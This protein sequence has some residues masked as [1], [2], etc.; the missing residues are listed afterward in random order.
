MVQDLEHLF[1]NSED[2]PTQ[3]LD[4]D[5]QGRLNDL[6]QSMGFRDLG[7]LKHHLRRLTSEQKQALLQQLQQIPADSSDLKAQVQDKFNTALEASIDQIFTSRNLPPP[8]FEPEI[9]SDVTLWNAASLASVHDALKT[10]EAQNPERLATLSREAGVSKEGEYK[11]LTFVREHN[12]QTTGSENFLK[13]ISE[14]TMIAHSSTSSGEVHIYDAAISGDNTRVTQ[15]VVDKMELLSRLASDK[16]GRKELVPNYTHDEIDS[17]GLQQR[18]GESEHDYGQRLRETLTD[19]YV[20]RFGGWENLQKSVNFITRYRDLV[21]RGEHLRDHPIPETGEEARDAT[22]AALTKLQN[23]GSDK[24]LQVACRMEQRDGIGH[25]QSFLKENAPP[26]TN[27]SNLE[28]DGI[29]G[30]RTGGVVKSFQ[31]G[32]AVNTFKERIEDDPHLPENKKEELIRFCNEQFRTL[33]EQPGKTNEI[34]GQ[35]RTRMQELIDGQEITDNTRT[36]L[37]EDVDNLT[38]LSHS[39]EGVFNRDTAEKMVNNWFNLVDSGRGYDLGEQLTMHELGHIWET[40]LDREKGNLGIRENWNKLF[41]SA[42]HSEGDGTSQMNTQTANDELHSDTVATTAYGSAEPDE[43]FAE[44][45]RVFAYDPKRLMRRS[46][47]KFLFMNHINHDQYDTSKILSMAHECGYSNDQILSRLDNLLGRGDHNIQFSG[48]FASEM[49]Q[50]YANLRAQLGSAPEPVDSRLNFNLSLGMNPPG[51]L[52]TLSSTLTPPTFTSEMMNPEPMNSGSFQLTEPTLSS[53]FAPGNGLF[54]PTTG[55]WSSFDLNQFRLPTSTDNSYR[56]QPNE[57][58]WVLD[59]V[60]N[61]YQDLQRQLSVPGLP[62]DQRDV[63]QSQIRQLDQQILQNGPGALTGASAEAMTAVDKAI[64]DQLCQGKSPNP[65]DL[66]RGYAVMAA[67]SIYQAT[68]AFDAR[69]HPELAEKLP[70]TFAI[71]LQDPN[72][73]HLLSPE[74]ARQYNQSYLFSSTLHQMDIIAQRMDDVQ[75]DK[76]MV[77]DTFADLHSNLAAVVDTSG[78]PLSPQDARRRADELLQDP[79]VQQV[80]QDASYDIGYGLKSLQTFAT[81]I[82]GLSSQAIHAMKPKDFER[83]MLM[84]MLTGQDRSQEQFSS[85]VSSYVYNEKAITG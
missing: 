55:L 26:G 9:G 82:G 4:S 81:S 17:R 43:D 62:D 40:Q 19:D 78:G 53:G 18:P 23:L 41:D 42:A 79:R 10:I 72:M 21:Y 37:S 36:H 16:N 30:S 39:R 66:K 74:N 73:Q 59:A 76:A 29:L 48:S 14:S 6:A 60:S 70:P 49:S 38:Q 32:M 27:T 45:S 22:I 61:R 52:R 64:Q 75:D 7:M 67:L 44:S 47:M 51:S 5:A 8:N 77:H 2:N 1:S 35:M 28:V 13:T 31:V 20:K 12:P 3:G 68:G 50:S 54:S 33:A 57:S 83:L 34:L 63:I 58:G 71:M 11:G 25:L 46:L 15:N 24:L 69:Q 65:A 85:L 80:F 84:A 56:P